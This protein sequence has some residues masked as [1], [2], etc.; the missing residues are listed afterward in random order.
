MVTI[1][2]GINRLEFLCGGYYHNTNFPQSELRTNTEDAVLY[3]KGQLESL[4]RLKSEK[5]IDACITSIEQYVGGEIGKSNFREKNNIHWIEDGIKYCDE[6]LTRI[7]ESNPADGESMSVEDISKKYE[8]KFLYFNGDEDG[9]KIIYVRNIHFKHDMLVVDGTVIDICNENHEDGDGVI[10]YDVEDYEFGCFW[11]FDDYDSV[12]ELE[13][14][15][16]SKPV[17]S[18][19]ETHVISAGEVAEEMISMIRWSVE[20]LVRNKELTSIFLKTESHLYSMTN[21]PE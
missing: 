5:T 13:E 6:I 12:D 1:E 19:Y 14:A 3:I 4:K 9:V 20:E 11:Y 16:Q 17:D 15:L 8:G 21:K 10:I 18:D 2:N 7:S